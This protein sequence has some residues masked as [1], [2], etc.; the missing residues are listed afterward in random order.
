MPT[1]LTATVASASQVNLSWN[2]S[3]DN[4]GVAGYEVYRDGSRIA[5]C[6]TTTYQVGSLAASTTYTFR[7]AAYDAAGNVSPQSATVS[8]TT[9]A[10]T[11]RTVDIYPGTNVFRPAAEGLRAGDTLIV[12]QGTYNE[13]ARM[14]IQGQG[15]SNAPIVIRGATGEARPVITRPA[16]AAL[17]NTINIEGNASYL[18]LIGLEIIGN[19]GDGISINGNVSY[20]TIEDNVIHDVDVAI[21]AHTNMDHITIRKNHIYQTGIGSGTGEG[22]YLGCN[23]GACVIRDS[24]IENNWIHDVLPGT[25]QGD[26]IEV[27][28][29]SYANIIRNNVIYN[30]SYPGIVVYGGG[31]GNNTVEGN[32][33]WGCPE[34][35]YVVADAMIQNN[36]VMRSNSG[37]SSYGHAQVASM[38]N[39][40]IANNT[41]YNCDEGLYIRWGGSNMTLANNAVYCPGQAAL[42]SG[43]GINGTIRSNYIEGSIDVA[44][45]GVRFLSGGSSSNAFVN[46]AGDDFWPKPGSILIG[47]ADPSSVPPNDFNSRTRTSFFDVGAYETDGLAAN[48]GWR[49]VQGFKPNPAAPAAPASLRIIR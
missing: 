12:H 40:T 33:V 6:S 26:G 47:N 39:V 2:A 19:G 9:L 8:A 3:T 7:V 46:P 27:K 32:V 36:I 35:I 22:M 1:G 29:G 38:R 25:T 41:L 15:L 45:D 10:V 34:G 49:I 14:S 4:I 24:L 37:I 43:Y 16:S 48:P 17:Q 31:A 30:R 44:I 23:Y 20:I 5:V 11:G 21:G 13:T 18:T 42:S 28:A